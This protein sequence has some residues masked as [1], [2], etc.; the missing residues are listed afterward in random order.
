MKTH[1]AD[2]MKDPFFAGLIFQAEHIIYQAGSDAKS[3][4]YPLTD[5]Q[6]RSAVIKTQ[7]K[8]QGADPA[9]QVTNVR[10]QCLADL[11]DSLLHAPN[12]LAEEVITENGQRTE[13]PLC[14]SD[15]VKTL[16][17]VADS[18]KT[19]KSPVPGSRDFLDYLQGFIAHGKL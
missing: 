9:I 3:K 17:T 15:W 6:V 14:L 10:E 18:I 2:R 19:R 4:G 8:L 16:E 7:K 11:I 12:A 1:P 5:S 13:K